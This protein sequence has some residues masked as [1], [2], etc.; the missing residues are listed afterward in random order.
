MTLQEFISW[1]NGQRLGKYNDGQFPGQCVSLIN[2]YC[3]RVLDVP[4]GAWGN[5]KDWAS[6]DNTAV[7]RY[8]DHVTDMQAGDILVYPATP[9]NAD[10]HIEIYIGNNQSLQ[11]NRLLDGTTHVSPIWGV[12]P[13][14]ILRSKNSKGADMLTPTQVDMAIKMGLHKEPTQE[15]LNN[16]DYQNSAGLLI[17]TLWN[18]GGRDL[19][20]A[21]KNK[22]S[23]Q[24]VKVSD[25]YI[26]K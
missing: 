22:V 8:F 9:T 6:T 19:Y 5:A 23:D 11:Q 21:S 2:Q 26:K 25:L 7:M 18:N 1:S 24:Y 3:W 10:G 4:A 14:A 20:E 15:D 17:E 13:S 16:P 12:T